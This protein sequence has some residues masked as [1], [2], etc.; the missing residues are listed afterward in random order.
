MSTKKLEQ[1]ARLINFDIS[2]LMM[3][4][5][6]SDQYGNVYMDQVKQWAKQNLGMDIKDESFKM[7]QQHINLLMDAGAIPDT[8]PLLLRYVNL[9]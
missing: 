7:E 4:Y 3:Y 1:L 9:Y 2:V 6:F 5:T 8:R